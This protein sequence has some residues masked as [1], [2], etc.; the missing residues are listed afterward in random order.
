MIT[1]RDYQEEISTKASELLREHKIAYLAM[2]CR[3]GKTLT[4][5]A[6]ADKFGAKSVLVVSKL[7][8]IPSINADYKTLAPSFSIEVVNYESVHKCSGQHDLVILDEAHSIGSFPVPSKRAKKI[9]SICK[10]LPIIYLSGTPS[11]E[12][13]AQLYHQFWVSSYSPF[14]QFTT[15]YRWAKSFVAIKQKMINGHLINDYSHANKNL[16]DKVCKP[17]FI[18]YSQEEAGFEAKIEEH[19]LEATMSPLTEIYMRQLKRDKVVNVSGVGGVGGDC[20]VLGDTPAKLLTKLHQLSSG[21]LIDGDGRH[22]IIDTSKADFVRRH[23]EG[24]KIALFYVYQAE[25]DL[26][27]KVF[28]NWTDVP[29]VFQESDDRVFIGQVRSAREG[30]RLDTADALIFFNLEYSYL[31]YEQGKNRLSSKER[32]SPARVYFICSNCGI[33]SKILEAV[34]SKQDF[35]YSYFKSKC[36]GGF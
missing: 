31:S 11:P 17:L 29:E 1:L 13:Y 2:E 7:K 6:S 4:A 16:I 30:V 8:A 28:P 18:D 25:A 14:K 19:V 21:T 32:T 3:T 23:F 34:H 33:E 35:T 10:N 36:Y 9:K 27:K 22:I 20:F 12:S 5:L 24:R 15:F 26:L